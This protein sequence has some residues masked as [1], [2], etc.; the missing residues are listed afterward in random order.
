MFNDLLVGVFLVCSLFVGGLWA[1]YPFKRLE[2]QRPSLVWLAVIFF[3]AAVCFMGFLVHDNGYEPSIQLVAAVFLFS[4]AYTLHYVAFCM[5]MRMSVLT[6]RVV[7]LK[8]RTRFSLC[9]HLP[10]HEALRLAML[11]RSD[12]WPDSTLRFLSRKRD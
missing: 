9:R 2:W 4:A 11:D 8:S 6:C 7:K 5:V 1:G 3:A 12:G 10:S